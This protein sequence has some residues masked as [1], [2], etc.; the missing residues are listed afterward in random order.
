V[1]ACCDLISASLTGGVVS[2][3]GALGKIALRTRSAPKQ[4]LQVSKSPSTPSLAEGAASPLSLLSKAG[5][6]DGQQGSLTG[7]TKRVALLEIEQLYSIIL[8]LEQIKRMQPQVNLLATAQGEMQHEHQAAL[9]A[10]QRKYATLV[11]EMWDKLHVTKP[12]ETRWVVP[13]SPSQPD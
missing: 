2:L 11:A 4:L 9:A 3:D 13:V 12:L 10:S 7:M 5:K 1:W 6:A 8:E